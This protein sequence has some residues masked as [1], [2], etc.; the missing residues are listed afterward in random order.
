MLQTQMVKR[1]HKENTQALCELNYKKLVHM[2][3][4]ITVFEHMT[5]I[6]EDHGL[7]V[8]VDVNERTPYTTLVTLKSCYI[9]C[10]E[11]SPETTMQVRMY[12]DAKVA[13]V[14]VIQ[15]HQRIRPHYAYPNSD[16]YYPDEKKQNNRLLADLLAFC[17]ANK[18]TKTY[19]PQQIEFN[20]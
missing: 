13:E 6:A 19:L 7:S 4:D 14:V 18:F 12:H 5:L 8:I 10:S 9:M 17:R 2:L 3:P 15:G 20:E 1:A 11:F 16:M